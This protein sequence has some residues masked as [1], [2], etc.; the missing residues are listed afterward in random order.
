MATGD[1]NRDGKLDLAVSAGASGLGTASVLLG[2]GDGTF[3]S[4]VDYEVGPNPT[5][6]EVADFNGDGK[7]DFA[8]DNQNCVGSP[9]QFGSISIL[10][11]RGDGTFQPHTYYCTGSTPSFTIADF[12]GDNRLDLAIAHQTC[13]PFSP[14]GA[15]AVSVLLGNGDGTFPRQVDNAI[16]VAPMSCPIAA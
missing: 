8:V 3:Q 11:G 13:I 16:S 14:C 2:N 7:L 15:G 1:F 6:I 12:N 9:C 10:L 4:H 5:F